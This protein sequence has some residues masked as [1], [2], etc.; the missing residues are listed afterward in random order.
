MRK[1]PIAINVFFIILGI[2]VPAIAIVLF[3]HFD[4]GALFNSWENKTANPDWRYILLIFF[5]ISLYFL[6]PLIGMLGFYIND[7]RKYKYK[8]LYY[9][10]KALNVH[11]L[12]LLSIKL[13]C[14]SI[15]ELDKVWGFT[16]F[17]SIKDVQTLIGYIVTFFIKQNIKIE[18]GLDEPKELKINTKEDS[19]NG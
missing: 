7:E 16:V 13:I 10:V 9:L 1:H 3:A 17:N 5:K 11:F 14:D 15:L 19:N 12:V 18:P 2:V 6:P 8:F 4:L